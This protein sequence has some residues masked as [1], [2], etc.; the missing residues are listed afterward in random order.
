VHAGA[1]M[2]MLRLLLWHYGGASYLL[3]TLSRKLLW[4]RAPIIANLPKI[5][6]LRG[7]LHL[8]G[9]CKRNDGRENYLKRKVGT[10]SWITVH[11]GAFSGAPYL[12]YALECS[13]WKCGVVALPRKLRAVTGP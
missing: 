13:H 8:G 11:A 2:T 5:R 12:L 9:C 4:G 1:L 10:G 3:Y 6:C 7:Y